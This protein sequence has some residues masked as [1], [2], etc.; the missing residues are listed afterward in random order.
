MSRIC[1]SFVCNQ[2]QAM[3]QAIWFT[4]LRLS[5]ERECSNLWLEEVWIIEAMAA[6][7]QAQECARRRQQWGTSA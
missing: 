7:L 5:A 3:H 1:V 4:L 6:V 2:V